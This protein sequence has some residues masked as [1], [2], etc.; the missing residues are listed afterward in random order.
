M[1]HALIKFMSVIWSEIQS[2]V[3][4]LV[5]PMEALSQTQKHIKTR[6]LDDKTS[7]IFFNVEFSNR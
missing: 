4:Y 1:K 3:V 6:L 2:L 5:S 7:N